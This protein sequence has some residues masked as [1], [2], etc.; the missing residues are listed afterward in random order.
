MKKLNILS[1]IAF[2]VILF[3][4]FKPWLWRGYNSWTEFDPSRRE[5]EI[6][7]H[8]IITISP[9]YVSI[10]TD[11]KLDAIIWF[12]NYETSFS[13]TIILASSFLSIFRYRKKFIN[14]ILNFISLIM[15]LFFIL[16][17]GG[18]GLGIGSVTFIGEGFKITLIGL[19][20]MFISSLFELL[21][22]E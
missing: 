6:Y 9:Y 11:N 4:I 16:S 5:P 12:V 18:R 7:Y 21:S 22:Q 3:G 10:I 14:F 2:I 17:L 19:T 8:K 1:I 13:G 15:I 20:L